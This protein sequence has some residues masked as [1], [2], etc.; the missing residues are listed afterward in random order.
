MNYNLKD[1]LLDRG[2][3]YFQIKKYAEALQDFNRLTEEL[4]VKDAVIF[5][6]KANCN[7]ALGNTD[8]ALK[9]YTKVINLDRSNE[10]ALIKRADLYVKTNKTPLAIADYRRVL[11]IN[12]DNPDAYIGRA[13]MYINQKRYDL[14][15]EDLNQSIKIKAS[16]EAYYWRGAVKSIKNDSKGACTDLKTAANMGFEEAQAKVDEL[17]P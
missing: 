14:A 15:M 16:G 12:P 5:I 11:T 17:C 7:T 8:L 3:A 13:K 10:D 1:V 6:K 2:N 4:K 9:D